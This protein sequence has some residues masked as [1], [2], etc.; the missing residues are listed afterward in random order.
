MRP[1]TH[2]SP[3]ERQVRSRLTRLLHEERILNGSLVTMARTCGNP[4]CRCAEA[5]KH[6]S[7]YLS[8]RTPD[9]RKMIYI[10]AALEQT[11]RDWVDN[12]REARRL[13]EE[14]SAASLA[15]LL[16]EK[17]SRRSSAG[18]RPVRAPKGR[19]S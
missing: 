9:G 10:P 13:M 5:H 17:Q 1:R 15:R 12:A 16:K 14:V 3:Q 4:R 6:V 2:L 8:I 11:V 7:L 18:G 19:R